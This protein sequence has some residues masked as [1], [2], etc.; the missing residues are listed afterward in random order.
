MSHSYDALDDS[1]YDIFDLDAYCSSL[2]PS[3]P[4]SEPVLNTPTPA[5]HL[6]RYPKMRSHPHPSPAVVSPPAVA[7]TT[8]LPVSVGKVNLTTGQ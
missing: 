3:V 8:S 1:V 4:D 5:S 6:K 2:S 7:T